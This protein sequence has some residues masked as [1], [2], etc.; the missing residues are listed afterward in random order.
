MGVRARAPPLVLAWLRRAWHHSA[1]GTRHSETA[2]VAKQK[3]PGCPAGQSK[4]AS[5]PLRLVTPYVAA[6][7]RALLRAV[8]PTINP[9]DPPRGA[10]TRAP[11]S[12]RPGRR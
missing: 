8:Q 9:A 1:K 10:V 6:A 12:S 3:Y 11:S 4:D 7:P 5:I 2:V